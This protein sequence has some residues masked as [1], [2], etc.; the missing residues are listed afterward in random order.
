M[1]KLQTLL[2]TVFCISVTSLFAQD[3][4]MS[5]LDDQTED[6]IQFIE[7]TFKGSRLINGHTVQTRKHRELEFLISHRFGRVNSGADELFGLDVSNI[8]LGLEYGLTKFLTVGVGRSSFDKTFDGFLKVKPLKQS[9]GAKSMPIS[10]VY[11]TSMAYKSL[12]NQDGFED[13]ES[14]LAYTHQILI[15]RKFSPGLSFQLMPTLIH[16]NKVEEING[17]NDQFALGIG[18]RV[19]LTQRVSLNAEYY[20]RYDAPENPDLFNSLAIGF[21]IE[22]GGHVFQLHFTNSRTMIERGFITETTGDYFGGDIH[23]GFNVSRVF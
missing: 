23:F 10:L 19:K 5:L 1:K 3:D 6:P 15:A 22:T 13:T 7:A 4:L 21:D 12:K 14:K 18:G 20:Y 16:R 8:R 11:F 9:K 2:I 17:D